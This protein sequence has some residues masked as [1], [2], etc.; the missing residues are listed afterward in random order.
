MLIGRKKRTIKD[1]ISIHQ[2]PSRVPRKNKT[3][4]KLFPLCA[5]QLGGVVGNE[6]LGGE[7]HLLELLGVGGGDL[8]TSDSDGR[9]IQVVPGVLGGQGEDLGT[10]T[11]A[12][13]TGLDG[14]QVTGLLDRLDD[15]LDIE[16]LDG[17]EVDDL[18]LDAVFLLELLS[19]DQRLANAAGEGDDGEVLAGALDLGLAELCETRQSLNN[20]TMVVVAMAY[21]NDEVVLLGL[22]AHREGETVE[23]PG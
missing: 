6:L 21:G 10:D 19:S 1:L 12:R 16:G 3:P 7:G 2:L 14:H 9:S 13:E 18:G 4:K 22:L 8:S 5:Q 15:G 20:S 23:K 17:T 11:E